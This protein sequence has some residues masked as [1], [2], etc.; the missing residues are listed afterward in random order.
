MYDTGFTL[1]KVK[2][3]LSKDEDI[4]NIDNKIF[5]KTNI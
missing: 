5:K 4:E 1:V 2:K 3:N